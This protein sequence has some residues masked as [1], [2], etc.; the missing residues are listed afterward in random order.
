MNRSGMGSPVFSISNLYRSCGEKNPSF[1][2]CCGGK[3]PPTVIDRCTRPL[4]VGLKKM[5]ESP[6]S[7]NGSSVTKGDS[8]WSAASTRPDGMTKFIK[9]I[10][11]TRNAVPALLKRKFFILTLLVR[12]KLTSKSAGVPIPMRQ[13][14]ANSPLN[15]PVSGWRIQRY[16]K[17]PACIPK[18]NQKTIICLELTIY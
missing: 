16:E 2:S 8:L 11:A 10:V 17:S 1:N 6:Q 7:A 13:V 18:T 5:N 3:N 9:T 4:F 12:L 15:S 14:K